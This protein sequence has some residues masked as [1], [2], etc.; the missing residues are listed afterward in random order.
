[1]YRSLH[2]ILYSFVAL[3]SRERFCGGCRLKLLSKKDA[4][5]QS[6][7]RNSGLVMIPDYANHLQICASKSPA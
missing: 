2:L 5:N 3:V 7:S 6:N 1:M 4:A